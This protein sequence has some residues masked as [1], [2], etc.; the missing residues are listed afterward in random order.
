MLGF[1]DIYGNDEDDDCISMNSNSSGAGAGAAGGDDKHAAGDKVRLFKMCVCCTVLV[2]SPAVESV[3][4]PAVLV[5]GTG[6]FSGTFTL[7]LSCPI[8]KFTTGLYTFTPAFLFPFFALSELANRHWGHL[9]HI[10]KWKRSME[11]P[12]HHHHQHN[13]KQHWSKCI[14]SSTHES[15]ETVITCDITIVTCGSIIKWQLT[16]TSF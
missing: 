10:R 3:P 9:Q 11:L 8:P 12:N 6:C 2:L 4:V 14:R 13:H 1:G 16:K 15:I 7:T 5:I